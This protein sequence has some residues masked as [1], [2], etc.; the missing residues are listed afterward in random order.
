LRDLPEGE[1]EPPRPA[2][3]E[4]AVQALVGLGYGAAEADRAVRAVVNRDGPAEAVELIRRA[5]QHLSG[6]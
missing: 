3:A 6:G 2:S 4:Q 5:L 1:G